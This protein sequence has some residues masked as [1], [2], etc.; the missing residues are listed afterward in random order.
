VL[1][2]NKVKVHSELLRFLEQSTALIYDNQYSLEQ[3]ELLSYA[4]HTISAVANPSKYEK[5]KIQFQKIT[6]SKPTA[7]SIFVYDAFNILFRAIATVGSKSEVIG[8]QIGK[9]DAYDGISGQI[10]FDKY[11]DLVRSIQFT[12]K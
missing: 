11:G 2:T 8:Q 1:L 3:E 6:S 9:M 10:E 7:Q 5:F 12:I 4:S